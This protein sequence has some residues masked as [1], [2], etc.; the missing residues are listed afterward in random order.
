MQPRR[1]DSLSRFE[2]LVKPSAAAKAV[3]VE[4]EKRG[5][6]IKAANGKSTRQMMIEGANKRRRYVCLNRKALLAE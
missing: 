1:A 3:L 4:L 2:G 5:I 6:L